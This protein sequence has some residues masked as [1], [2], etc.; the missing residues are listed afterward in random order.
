MQTDGTHNAV[1]TTAR[2]NEKIPSAVLKKRANAVSLIQNLPKTVVGGNES[3]FLRSDYDGKWVKLNRKEIGK[4][5]FLR[6][7][8][9]VC[10][11]YNFTVN[12]VVD[13]GCPQTSLAPWSECGRIIRSTH[14]Q[15]SAAIELTSSEI[16]FN[17][18]YPTR[19]PELS[20]GSLAVEVNYDF[21]ELDQ[22]LCEHVKSIYENEGRKQWPG[23]LASTVARD[24]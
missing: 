17:F 9:L 8:I 22:P 11:I 19:E 16:V 2:R 1:E 14:W 13:D 24:M 20:L 5:T 23:S 18:R 6:Y 12:W 3:G 15:P 4:F 21:H 10:L 7:D